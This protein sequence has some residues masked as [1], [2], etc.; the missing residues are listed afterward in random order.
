MRPSTLVPV[1]ALSGAV[2]IGGGR[3]YSGTQEI[4]VG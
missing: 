1:L 2:S 4:V 3:I